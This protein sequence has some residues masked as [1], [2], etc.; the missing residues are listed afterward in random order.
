MG[1][2]LPINDISVNNRR[3]DD[4]ILIKYDFKSLTRPA[5]TVA[6]MWEKGNFLFK[7]KNTYIAG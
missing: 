3:V 4:E 7:S 6:M 1:E 2:T 5:C